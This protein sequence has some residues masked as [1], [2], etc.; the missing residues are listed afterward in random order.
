MVTANRKLEKIEQLGNKI[1]L[2]KNIKQV[3]R[4]DEITEEVY[5]EWQ[6]E[7]TVIFEDE[8]ANI[9]DIEENFDMYFEW[10]KEKRENEKA[11]KQKAKKVRELIDEKYDLADLKE[12]V[13][14]LVA[15][16]LL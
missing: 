3:E 15:N 8:I 12:I 5:T 13:D 7:Q 6:A 14:E 11:R 4:E 16:Y 2:N 9:E 10:A 1:Y